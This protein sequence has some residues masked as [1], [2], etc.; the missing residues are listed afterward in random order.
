MIS[1]IGNTGFIGKN[2]SDQM[3]CEKVYNSSNINDLTLSTHHTLVCSAPSASKWLINKDPVKDLHNI[4]DIFQLISSAK[5]NN[6]VL[7]S[8]IDT[9][10]YLTDNNEDQSF[11]VDYLDTSY[12]GNRSIFEKFVVENIPNSHVIRLPALF[13]K[14]LKKNSFFDLMTDNPYYKNIC[15]QD[16]Y[17]WYDLKNI[18]KTIEYVINNNIKI[19]NAFS[20]PIYMETIIDNFFSDKKEFCTGIKKSS[21]D[22]TSIYSKSGYLYTESEILSSMKEFLNDK[23]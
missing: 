8:T 11:K 19:L 5:F 3:N 18:S 10:S 14:Y 7:I 22:Y 4:L 17:Q 1:L 23:N 12:G 15:L 13:G 20:E 2:I 9:L 16:K 6:F 21:Y